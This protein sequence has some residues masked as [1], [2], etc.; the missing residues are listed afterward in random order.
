LFMKRISDLAKL[1][2]FVQLP[3]YRHR[4]APSAKRPMSDQE[5]ALAIREL[6]R[7]QANETAQQARES[8][9]AALRRFHHALSE[10]DNCAAERAH[11]LQQ[12]TRKL[13]RD[14][15]PDT[16]VGRK[17]QEPFPNHDQD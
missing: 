2:G 6:K 11:D 17:T 10:E 16:F 12:T 5:L 14:P 4:L 13:L 8:G 1:L 9:V 15:A 7:A 3:P